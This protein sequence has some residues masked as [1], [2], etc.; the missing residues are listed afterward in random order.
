M[1]WSQRQQGRGAGWEGGEWSR[2]K[3][4]SLPPTLILSLGQ[5]SQ[6]LVRTLAAHLN[7]ISRTKPGPCS[8]VG[9]TAADP[10]D[11]PLESGRSFPALTGGRVTA[12]SACPGPP[13]KG[14]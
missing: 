11:W 4:G 7:P 6:G 14:D 2:E 5:G 10:E 9:I 13:S 8:G 1:P 3:R 12:E